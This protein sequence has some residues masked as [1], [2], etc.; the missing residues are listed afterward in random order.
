MY[1]IVGGLHLKNDKQKINNTIRKLKKINPTYILPCHYTGYV[2]VNRMIEEFSE[3]RVITS[4][5][6]SF[7]VGEKWSI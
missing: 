6:G 5:T 2:A 3:E 1:G 4:P 7:S